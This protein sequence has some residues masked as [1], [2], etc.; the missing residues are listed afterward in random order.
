[1]RLTKL[2]AK[3]IS[4]NFLGLANQRIPRD[5]S[6]RWNSWY[7]MLSTAWIMR[8]FVEEFFDLYT[9]AQLIEDRLDDNE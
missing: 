2:P 6:T 1:M 8:D 7:M 9:D 3:L 5:N 4:L